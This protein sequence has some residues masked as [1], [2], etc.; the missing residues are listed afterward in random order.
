MP[1]K[2]PDY[3]LVKELR[4]NILTIPSLGVKTLTVLAFDEPGI[5][6][7]GGADIGRAPGG[8]SDLSGEVRAHYASQV[9]TILQKSRGFAGDG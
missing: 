4:G 1:T 5:A 6:H 3:Q 9:K 7:A 2:Y 8:R